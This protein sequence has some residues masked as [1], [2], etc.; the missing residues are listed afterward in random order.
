MKNIIKILKKAGLFLFGIVLIIW[1]YKVNATNLEEKVKAEEDKKNKEAEQSIITP[2]AEE[3]TIEKAEAPKE[4]ETKKEPAAPKVANGQKEVQQ[5]KPRIPAATPAKTPSTTSVAEKKT[6]SKAS[7]EPA[8]VE[9]PKQTVIEK[10]T[11]EESS[12]TE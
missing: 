11:P 2:Q 10:A 3:A 7:E 8:K 5:T 4:P 1:G 9:E 12:G 6:E